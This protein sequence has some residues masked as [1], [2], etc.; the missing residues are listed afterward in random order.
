MIEYLPK[1]NSKNIQNI[2]A[3][4]YIYRTIGISPLYFIITLLWAFPSITNFRNLHCWELCPNICGL[5]GVIIKIVIFAFLM[6][7]LNFTMI[8]LLFLLN[9]PFRWPLNECENLWYSLYLWVKNCKNNN[10][11]IIR[12][13]CINYCLNFSSIH[14]PITYNSDASNYLKKELK[15]DFFQSVNYHNLLQLS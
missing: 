10:D 9:Y 2:F 7:Y 15:K 11:R 1:K 5:I 6:E 3:N 4:V 13:C 8:G 14:F 12:L